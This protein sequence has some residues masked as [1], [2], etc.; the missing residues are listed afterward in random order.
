[1]TQQRLEKQKVTYSYGSYNKIIGIEQRIR[2]TEGCPNQC[3]YCYE[4]REFKIFGI[5]EIVRNYVTIIDMNLL[6]KKEALN[7]IKELGSKRV[8]GKVVEYE[9]MCGVDFRFMTQETANLLKENRFKNIR[10]AWDWTFKDQYKIVDTIKMFLKAGYNSKDLM[11]FMICNWRISYQECL[12][13]LDLLKIWRVQVADCYFDNY[14]SPKIIPIHWTSEQ[15]K[16]F[17]SK[18]RTHNQMVNFGI[19]P[20]EKWKQ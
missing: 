1:M 19:D 7:I 10:I 11:I 4:P 14:V 3:P 9:L 12:R 20:D 5:P 13:K 16:D 2:I 15:I 18:C 8:N 17:R 6:A